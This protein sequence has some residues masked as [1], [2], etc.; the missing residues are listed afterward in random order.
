MLVILELL[1]TKAVSTGIHDRF[2]LMVIGCTVRPQ[3]NSEL[4][5]L[6]LNWC[7]Y[8]SFSISK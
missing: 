7:G 4:P 6:L 1:L 8:I 3:L 5:L 2:R